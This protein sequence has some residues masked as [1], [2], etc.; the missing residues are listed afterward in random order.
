MIGRTVLAALLLLVVSGCASKPPEPKE[1]AESWIGQPVDKL[2]AS[3]GQ[4]DKIEEV[5]SG[6]QVYSWHA[7]RRYIQA[8]QCG[9]TGIRS[10]GPCSA[11]RVL[12]FTCDFDFS[13][14]PEG[15]ITAAEGSGRCLPIPGLEA[16]TS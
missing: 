9:T 7:E 12:R 15:R 1:L 16:P 3:W 6:R 2:I 13:T 5:N 14:D 11:A 10:I 4:P 8:P